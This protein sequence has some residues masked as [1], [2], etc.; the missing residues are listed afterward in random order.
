M[1]ALIELTRKYTPMGEEDPLWIVNPRFIV[2][3][4]NTPSGNASVFVE[5]RQ[6]VQVTQSASEILKMVNGQ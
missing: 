5:G 2:D 1:K 4:I 3:I 6:A